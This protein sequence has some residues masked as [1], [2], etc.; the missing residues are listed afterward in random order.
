MLGRPRHK[1][2]CCTLLFEMLKATV[3]FI[4][5]AIASALTMESV[6][7]FKFGILAPPLFSFVNMY[8]VH[9][10]NSLYIAILCA[11]LQGIK[12]NFGF[13]CPKIKLLQPFDLVGFSPAS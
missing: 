12:L 5:P 6:R 11:Q 9:V 13:K 1:L 8:F 2:F 10:K 7:D 3:T 4:T